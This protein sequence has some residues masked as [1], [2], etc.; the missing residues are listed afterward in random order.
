MNM[1]CSMSTKKCECRENMRWNTDVLECQIYIDV[2]CSEETE[3]KTSMLNKTHN[4]VFIKSQPITTILRKYH[5]G[6][7]NR[8]IFS[9]SPSQTTD[10]SRL[11]YLDLTNIKGRKVKQIF[12]RELSTISYQYK[13]LKK[14]GLISMYALKKQLKYLQSSISNRIVSNSLVIIVIQAVLKNV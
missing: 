1:F 13:K 11:L 8:P 5:I 14:E 7:R 6:L 12:C 2:D 4:R 3:N 10:K 9:L